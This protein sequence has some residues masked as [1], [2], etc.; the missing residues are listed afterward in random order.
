MDVRHLQVLRELGERGSVA[1]VAHALHVTPSAVSQQLGALHRAV[2]VPLTERSG[3]RLVLTATGQALAAAAVDV[4][5]A[6]DRAERAV[7]AYLDDEA[8]PVTVAAFHS[9]A[10]AYFAPL[11]QACAATS[12]PVVHCADAD[13]AQAD[14]PAL[15]ADY[16]LVLAHRLAHSPPWPTDRLAVVPLVYEPLYIAL[17]AAHPLAAKPELTAADVS[18]EPWIS[19]HDGFPLQ[20]T[21]AAIAAAAGRP[22]EIKHRINEFT[23]TASVVASG[24]A[25]ALLPGYTTVPDPAITLRPLADLPAGRHIDVLTRPET[26]H[27]AAAQ[28]VLRSLQAITAA[29]TSQ[30]R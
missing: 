24:A 17:P 27:R 18:A 30:S 15:V 4:S 20:G 26:L 7:D 14:F 29:P 19:V 21:L 22:L 1:A 10:L 16:D 2:R 25:I 13:V 8:A 3:R 11:L 5:A 23:V 6:L 9:E 12:G 28:T